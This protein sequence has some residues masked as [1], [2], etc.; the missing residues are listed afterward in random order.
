MRLQPAHLGGIQRRRM[1]AL[2][3]H[4]QRVA[5]K[6]PVAPVFGGEVVQAEERPLG[7]APLHVLE[8]E[9]QNRLGLTRQNAVARQMHRG[10]GGH[11]AIA[12][13]EQR[14]AG[15][16]Y[17]HQQL[18]ADADTGVHAGHED[19]IDQVVV[20]ARILECHPHRLPCEFGQGA[21][22]GQWGEGCY[23]HS[24]DQHSFRHGCSPRSVTRGE[25]PHW[26]RNLLGEKVC[27]EGGR[28]PPSAWGDVRRR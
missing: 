16:A 10:T 7:D 8:T 3:D 6:D 26:A 25:V 20:D 14:N 4:G 12:H 23:P 2:G 22:N 18:F 27:P 21:S 13:A 9:D 11:T 17:L 28:A 5:G 24:C 1:V 15:Q 19:L